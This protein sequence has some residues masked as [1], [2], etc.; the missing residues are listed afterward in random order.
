MA[1]LQPCPACK[2]YMPHKGVECPHCGYRTDCVCCYLYE[3]Q[4]EELVCNIP[5]VW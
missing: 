1:I 5:V 3:N 2:K 4:E